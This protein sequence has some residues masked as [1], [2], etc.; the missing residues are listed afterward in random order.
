MGYYFEGLDREVKQAYSIANQAKSKGYDPDN[1]VRIPLA[2]NMAER[3]I[4]LISAVAPQVVG[5]GIVERIPELEKEYGKLDWRVAFKIAEETAGE[6]FCKFKNKKEAME[7]ALRVGLAY[8]TVGVVASPLEGF[9]RLELKM[10]TDGREYF[11]LYF[12]GP[13]R[14]AGTTAV[15]AF[16]ALADYIRKSMGYAE[17]DP[18]EIEVK[19]IVTEINDFHERATNLQYLPSPQELKFMAEHLPVQISGDP[20]EKYEVSNYKDLPRIETNFLRNGVCLVFAEALCQKAAKFIGKFSKWYKE[21][22][23]EHWNFLISFTELQKRLRA[24]K[25]VQATDEKILPDYHFIKDIVAG[26]PVITHPLRQGGLRLRY[27]RTRASGFSSTALHPATMVILKGFIAI[28]TQL[29]SERPAKSTVISS[30][31]SIEGPIVKLKNRAVKNLQ[32]QEEAKAVLNEIEEILYVGDILISYGDFLNRAHK[33]V[34][35]GF[36]EEWWLQCLKRAIIEKQNAGQISPN[37][38]QLPDPRQIGLQ[39]AVKLSKDYKI[40]LHPKYIFYW[41]A[42]TSDEFVSLYNCLRSAEK[43]E[44]RLIINNF[45]CKRALELIGL[46]HSVASNEYII[47][48]KE[49]AEALFLNLGNMGKDIEKELIQDSE[50]FSDATPLEMV[51]HISQFTIKDKLGTFIGARMGRP[52][53]A[54]IRKMLGSPHALFPVG[55]EGGK[56]RS[57]QS[58]LTAGKVT[59]EFPIN[60]CENCNRKTIY[61]V[62][63]N[64]NKKAVKLYFCRHCNEEKTECL[65]HGSGQMYRLQAIDINHY[66]ASALGQ[67]G[68]RNSLELVKGVRGLSS[69]EHIPEH[70]TKALL[71]AKHK[72]HV[73]KDGT[74][75]YDMTEMAITHFK[76]KEISVTIEKIKELGYKEDIFNNEL[77]DENQILE[78]KPQDI[79]LPACR[80]S[81]DEGADEILFRTGCFIDELLEKLYCLPR[82]YDFKTKED[83]IGN[84][85]VAMSPHTSAGIVA[86]IIGFSRTQGFFAHPLLHSI[87]RRDIDGDEAGIILLMDCLLN[88]SRKYLPNTRGITQDAPMVITSMLVASEVDD[89]VFDMDVCSEYPL[90]LYESAEQYKVPFDVRVTKLKDYLGTEKQYEGLRFTH[91]ISDINEGIRCS[92]YKLLP[93]MREKVREQLEIARQIRAVDEVDV[94]RLVIERHFLRDIKGNLRKFSM[95]TFRCVMCNEIFRRP[96]LLGKC[97]KC[98][99]R[100]VFTISE[101]SIIKYLNPALEIIARYNV[102]SYLKQAMEL[103]NERIESVFGKEP[104]IQEGLN[105]WFGS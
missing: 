92:T 21:F 42:I 75:R 72:I 4:G 15:C 101:G 88:F 43:L 81:L 31:D 29:K 52:E 45:I 13:I 32:T 79:I 6:K 98:N 51:N 11:A 47:I 3:I 61:P 10:R 96:P 97:T 100:I 73:N 69:A 56:M 49:N 70:L 89:M 5:S 87:M 28:G 34:P 95:Q 41:N 46:P 53:K 76:P 22:N 99:G 20:S 62:C 38:A 60:F 44:G 36:N 37:P 103:L 17:Y 84:L 66:Y 78:L 9:T 24:K 85:V 23:M 14:S 59:A 40:P 25:I 91:D 18:S 2:R 16:V 55:K 104:E 82:F 68:M 33:L 90:E 1:E 71:R 48:E 8:L 94:A 65:L 27:G 19:R 58:A 67:I 64:C 30:C 12:S 26:R 105:K 57:F 39:E 35:A 93:S 7:V 83:L 86:R 54:K 74:I 77:R 63:E 80:E 102:P 50:S